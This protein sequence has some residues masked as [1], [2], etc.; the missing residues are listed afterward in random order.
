M[1]I[2]ILVDP[3]CAGHRLSAGMVFARL[4][5]AEVNGGSLIFICS[6]ATLAGYDDERNFDWP[7]AP[8]G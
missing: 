5:A 7:G 6:L 2:L 3:N 8:P 1:V 4:G